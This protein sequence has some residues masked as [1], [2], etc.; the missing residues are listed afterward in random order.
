MPYGS[1]WHLL[2]YLGRHR[3]LFERRVREATGGDILDWIDHPWSPAGKAVYFDG[4]RFDAEWKA[5]DF[6]ASDNTAR[7]DW[8]KF[9]PHIGNQP[10]WDAVGWLRVNTHVELLLVEAKSHLG[11]LR[12]SC[13]AQLHGGLPLIR[14]A[15]DRGKKAFGVLPTAD[16]LQPYYQFCNRLTVL[17]F[18]TRNGVGARLLFV[19][20]CGDTNPSGQC[21]QD[22]AGWEPAL[23]AMHQHIGLT[24]QD[25]L[26]ARVHKLFLPVVQGSV[27]ANVR[28]D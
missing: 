8:N 10:N 14:Q 26:Q 23:R 15:L 2:R 20:F 9:W 22:E 6:L 27:S 3:R 21:P 17:D 13:D 1:E 28:P 24:G 12:S 25:T 7:M 19:Y 16:W 4:P 5:L 18:L 11:E